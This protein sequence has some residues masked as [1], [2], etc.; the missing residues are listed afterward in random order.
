MEAGIVEDDHRAFGQFRQKDFC[1]PFVE[2]SA[3]AHADKPAGC[4]QFCHEQ[5]RNDADAGAAVA[6]ACSE[7]SL[8]FRATPVG[9][10][11]VIVDA[12][13]IDPDA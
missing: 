13:F 2:H 9:V 11:F 10:G 12:R 8:P 3:V 5:S 7:A 6:W 4:E 1:E